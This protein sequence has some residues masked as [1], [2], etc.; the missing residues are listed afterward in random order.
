MYVFINA[1]ILL[2]KTISPVVSIL[3]RYTESEI[4]I[5]VSLT[6]KNLC[7]SA[8]EYKIVTK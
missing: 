4:L 6:M 8:L 3:I 2:V 7:P 1:Y 5:H